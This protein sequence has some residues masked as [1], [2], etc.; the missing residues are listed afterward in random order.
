MPALA[1]TWNLNSPVRIPLC[2]MG[3]WPAGDRRTNTLSPVWIVPLP[4]PPRL[5]KSSEYSVRVPGVGSEARQM[6]VGA[7]CE[8]T[9]LW[10]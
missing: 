4:K 5:L 9:E 2:V 10:L 6:R 3:D 1:R 8:H 7:G